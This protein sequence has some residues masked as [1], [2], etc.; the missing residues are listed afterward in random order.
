MSEAFSLDAAIAALYPAFAALPPAQRE[1][2]LAGLAVL[3]APRGTRLFD[4]GT[5]C[6]GFPLVLSG[7]VRVT[8]SAEDGRGLELY[9][10]L[11]GQ[12]CIVSTG[13]LIQGRPL[14]A[15]GFAAEDTRLVLMDRDAFLE[16]SAD[17]EVRRFVFGV[18]AERMAD[19]CELVEAVAF[20][21][22]DRR[23]AEL[24]LGHGRQVSTSHQ[25]LAQ[26]LGTSREIVSRL[27]SRFARDGW[28]RTGRESVEIL[29]AAALRAL[30]A[31]AP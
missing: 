16:A 21:R 24:L 3:E 18:F 14:S 4:A 8:R 6:R 26:R 1:R 9:R 12:I 13:C 7:S 28:I 20:H 2:L 29:D 31:G 17:L 5:P 10:V 25:D 11:P 30:A 27:M 22:L 15:D 19:L 23:L